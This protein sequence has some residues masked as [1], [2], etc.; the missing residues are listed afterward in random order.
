MSPLS[1]WRVACGLIVHM[2]ASCQQIHVGETP[3]PLLAW[4]G[5]CAMSSWRAR[6]RGRVSNVFWWPRCVQLNLAAFSSPTTAGSPVM[7][8]YFTP[9][10]CP[11]QQFGF[12]VHIIIRTTQRRERHTVAT[13]PFNA[14][15][16]TFLAFATLMLIHCRVAAAEQSMRSARTSSCGCNLMLT[17]DTIGM[18]RHIP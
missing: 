5:T 3:Y 16:F 12:C 8:G 9:D 14:P 4:H 11:H 7:M 2:L 1:E 17:S 13:Y 15:S 6:T 18:S 10:T